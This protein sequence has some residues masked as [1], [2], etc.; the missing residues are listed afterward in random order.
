[1]KGEDWSGIEKF[2]KYDEKTGLAYFVNHSNRT[3]VA[4]AKRIDMMEF[5][6]NC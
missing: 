6:L 4:I 2:I 5:T 1:M 3:F